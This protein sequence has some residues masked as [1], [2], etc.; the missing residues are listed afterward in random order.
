MRKPLV[1]HVVIGLV[2]GIM[3]SGCGSTG[4]ARSGAAPDPAVLRIGVTPNFPPLVYLSGRQPLGVEVD[5]GNLLAD[6]LTVYE[7]TEQLIAS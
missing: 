6:E 1:G 7:L 4:P 3:L 2:F 5:F